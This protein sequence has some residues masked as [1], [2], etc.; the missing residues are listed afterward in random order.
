MAGNSASAKGNPASKRM[1]N[2]ALKSRRERSW[3]RGQARKLVNRQANQARE[4]NNKNVPLSERPWQI[5]Q[6][7][8]A[9]R[10]KPLGD[11]WVKRHKED[12]LS[13]S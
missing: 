13:A 9:Q 4:N 7:A 5:S 6:A 8:R 10:R 1:S 2:P 3:K 12:V 11:L